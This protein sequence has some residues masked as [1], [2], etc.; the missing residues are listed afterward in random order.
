M[1]LVLKIKICSDDQYKPM[2]SVNGRQL[3]TLKMRFDGG[4]SYVI[5][6]LG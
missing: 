5:F 3:I 2:W 4:K 6:K 1:I